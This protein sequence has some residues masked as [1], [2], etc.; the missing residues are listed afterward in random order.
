M[1]WGIDVGDGLCV[2]TDGGNGSCLGTDVGN[3]SCVGTDVGNWSAN[4][5]VEAEDGSCLGRVVADGGQGHYKQESLFMNN[6]W[7]F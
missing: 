6:E 5:I 3:G 7:K 2:G 1:D 4:A